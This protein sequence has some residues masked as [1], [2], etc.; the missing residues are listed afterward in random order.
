MP[1]TINV[2]PKRQKYIKN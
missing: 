1:T 2:M